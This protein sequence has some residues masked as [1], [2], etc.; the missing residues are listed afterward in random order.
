MKKYNFGA[1][2]SILP[3]EVIRATA[4]ACLNFDG[5][6]LSLM[7]ISHRSANFQAVIDE[8][9]ALVAELLQLPEDYSV[10]FLGGGAST[11]FCYVPYNLLERKAAYLNTG[12]WAKNA[13]K[14]AKLF[15]EV[16]EVASSE[17]ANYTY[18]PKG[19]TVPADVDYFHV[20]TNNTIYGTELHEDLDSPVPVVADMSSDI[21]SRQIDVSKYA[22]IYGGAQKNLSMAGVTF[23]IVRTDILGKVSRPLPSII[24][25]RTHIAGGSMFNTPPVLPIFTS[26]QTLRW[27][28]EQG[29]VAE[30][31]R[32]AKE[33]ADLLYA[34]IDRNP[35]FRGT[36]TDKA[37]RSYMNV[38]FVMA[39]G[40]EELEAEFLKF[41]T[42]RGMHGI[43]GHRSVGG[44]RA[45]IYNAMPLEGV[46][47]LVETMKQ[48]EQEH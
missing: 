33:K 37:D 43:K 39:E 48:F 17:D 42:A 1:G 29:G 19:F 2:P 31:E 7:E 22:L 25:Y 6:D 10:I 47:A 5:M 40:K 20:T 11:Q 21:F 32:R 24:D 28:K 8:A 46:Q 27:I 13:L 26:L 16:V 30:M 12:T 14:E 36:V 38:C 18:L 3:Q 9:R 45:S 15:G 34:E 44:F 4:D 35:F 23:V 41:A